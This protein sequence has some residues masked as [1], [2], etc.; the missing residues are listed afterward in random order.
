MDGLRLRCNGDNDR[1]EIAKGNRTPYIK[2]RLVQYGHVEKLTQG[3]GTGT[4]EPGLR[5]TRG[6]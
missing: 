4:G 3:G 6:T 1:K 2:P 5:R